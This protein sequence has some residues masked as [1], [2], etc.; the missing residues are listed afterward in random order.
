MENFKYNYLD[1]KLSHTQYT[2]IKE[3]GGKENNTNNVI[4][5]MILYLEKYIFV[6]ANQICNYKWL[7]R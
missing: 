3:E 2:L 4:T 1:K 6:V 7:R 5:L